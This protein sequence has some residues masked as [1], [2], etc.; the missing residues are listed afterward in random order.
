MGIKL[1]Q[2]YGTI[3]ATFVSRFTVQIIA[4]NSSCKFIFISKYKPKLKLLAKYVMII[5]VLTINGE[6]EME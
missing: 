2:G 6:D 1:G 3:L 4:N 5:R